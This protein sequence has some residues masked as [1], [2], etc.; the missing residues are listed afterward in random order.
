[1]RG[2]AACCACDSATPTRRATSRRLT[3]RCSSR[4]RARCASASPPPRAPTAGSASPRHSCSSSRSRRV[5]WSPC[6]SCR[7]FACVGAR[8]TSGRPPS[9]RVAHFG[10]GRARPP[11]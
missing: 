4:S 9:E 3:R 8:V 10:G 7:A 2:P 5:V 11:P 6:R 1:M